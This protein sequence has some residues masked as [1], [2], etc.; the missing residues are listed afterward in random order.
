MTISGICVDN[1]LDSPMNPPSIIKSL[2]TDITLSNRLHSHLLVSDNT[3]MLLSSCPC[4][5][6]RP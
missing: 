1:H 2:D 6:R 3:I 4:Q 5:L